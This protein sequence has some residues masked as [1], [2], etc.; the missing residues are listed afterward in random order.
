VGLI[1]VSIFDFFQKRPRAFWAVL[2]LFVGSG[3][4]SAFKIHVNENIAEIFPDDEK[5]KTFNKVFQSRALEKLVFMISLKDS[6]MSDP[7]E[8]I[9]YTDSLVSEMEPMNGRF[10]DAITYRIEDEQA[11][12]LLNLV[13]EH[14]PL[15]LSD[16]DYVKLDSLFQPAVLKERI[17]NHYRQV[18]SPT[19]IFSKRILSKD[20]LGISFLGLRKLQQLRYDDNYQLYNNC[21]FTKDQKRLIFFVAPKFHSSETGKNIQFIDELNDLLSTVREKNK[22]IQVSYF[23]GTAVAVENARQIRKD[24]R[25]TVTLMVIILA[26][27][28]IWFFKRRRAALLILVPV[29]FGAL[30]SIACLTIIKGHISVLALAAG[31]II[32]GIAVNYSLHFIIHLQHERDK[33]ATIRDLAGPLT[34]GSATTVLA[35]FGLQFA[36]AAIL[37]DI[38]LFAGFSLIG[39]ALSSLI[40]LSHFLKINHFEIEEKKQ[41]YFAKFFTVDSLR[42]KWTVIFI[43]V[44]TPVFFYFANGAKFNDD[45]NKLNFMSAD[46][47]KAQKDFFSINEVSLQSIYLVV[48]GSTKQQAL[49]RSEVVQRELAHLKQVGSVGRFSSPSLLIQSDSIQQKKIQQWNTFWSKERKQELEKKLRSEGKELKFSETVYESFQKFIDTQFKPI[50]DSTELILQQ[51]YF[52]ESFID[53]KGE[54]LVVTQ[55][56]VDKSQKEK[57]YSA[58]TQTQGVI[59]LDRQSLVAGFIRKV[60]ADFTFLVTFTSLLVFGA[61]LLAYGRIELTLITFVPMFVTWIWIL[62]IMALLNIEFNIINVM[63]STFIFGLGDDYSIFTTDGLLQKYKTGKENLSSIRIS[64]FISAITTT[65]GLGVLIFAKHPALQS[66]AFIS[67]TGIVCVFVMSQ[68]LQ[69]FLFQ[70]LIADRVKRGLSPMT[71]WGLVKSIFAFAYFILGCVLLAVIGFILRR[72]IP[73]QKKGMRLAYHHLLRFFSASLVYIMAN[74]KK[75][76]INAQGVFDKPSIIIANHSSFLDIL[77]TTMLSPKLILLTN[78]WVWN[79]PFFGAAV[80][81]AEYYPVD[82]GAE[83]AV[84]RLRE[85][86]SEGFSIVIF[87]EGTRSV[88]GTIQRFH[89]GAFYLAEKLQVDI[90]P[91][92]IHGTKDTMRK[93]DFYLNDGTMTLKF[94][95]PIA[96]ADE[97]WGKTYQERTKSI[98]H[99]FKHEFES[100]KHTTETPEY[101][102]GKLQLN[103]LYKG[104]VLEWYMYVK[105]R[106]EHYYK[107][108]NSLVPP[109]AKVLDLGCGYG[110]LS[111]QLQFLSNERSITGVDYDQDKIETAT[112][113]YLKTEQLTFFCADITLFEIKNF[114]VIILSDV[115]HYLTSEQQKEVLKKCFAGINPGGKIIVRDGN[116]ELNQRHFGTVLSEFF[117]IK[118]F[119]F[120]KAVQ[121]INFMPAETIKQLAAQSGFNV[122][123]VDTTKFTSNVIFVIQ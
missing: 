24:T 91:L 108:F 37:R 26:A 65:V 22:R 60:N 43:A 100:F 119:R 39:A 12:E 3:V 111:Y 44:L 90:R 35:F 84:E 30:F 53:E 10:I 31:S 73:F 109:K 38:G 104:P 28:V 19:G 122:E 51:K 80:R 92:L 18:I 120:N 97:T 114:D 46:L 117:S 78:R 102:K 107:I 77:T 2:I 45:M 25:L 47:L 14:L 79:S 105:L 86:I 99:Y 95:P 81:L 29:F 52:P 5:A 62:G 74:V 1:F 6:T 59:G 41:N 94:L 23:G 57:V 116:P 113:G 42:N 58:I 15:F 11:L 61:L 7:D 34:L 70:W 17:N 9:S 123:V 88:D 75:R 66:V 93:G 110:F 85:K 106:M 69:P 36:N 68:T 8:L 101:F 103:Y 115:L 54:T 50:T 71:L 16:D 4:F 98:S 72:L 40:F 87:P 32:F 96:A 82:D 83:D 56:L 112:H 27:F 67:L 21:L 33:R 89:K 55:A 121:N 13:T 48:N 76:V 64:V 118:L 63:V 49:Q 20:I